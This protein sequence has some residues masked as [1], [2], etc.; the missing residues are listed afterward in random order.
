MNARQTRRVSRR[1]SGNRPA[2]RISLIAAGA[3]VPV[4]VVGYALTAAT[5]GPV[6]DAAYGS[7]Y[8]AK[9][10]AYG[11]K[12]DGGWGR[13]GYT[14]MPG[15]AG[16]RSRCAGRAGHRRRRPR[17]SRRGPGQ[18]RGRAGKYRAPQRRPGRQ[19]GHHEQ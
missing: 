16:D 4:A 6:T 17:G 9:L 12:D 11:A 8:G 1:R 15:P 18:R 7:P 14:M 13:G 3:C 10:H 2:L 5:G 19:R